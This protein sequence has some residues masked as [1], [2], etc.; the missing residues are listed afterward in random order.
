MRTMYLEKLANDKVA[1]RTASHGP[2]HVIVQFKIVDDKDGNCMSI[3]ALD[4]DLMLTDRLAPVLTFNNYASF[5]IVSGDIDAV[6]CAIVLFKNDLEYGVNRLV[7]IQ[8]MRQFF[9]ALK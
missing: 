1:V 9:S 2:N 5:K 4:I 3:K 6:V 8:E 7:D